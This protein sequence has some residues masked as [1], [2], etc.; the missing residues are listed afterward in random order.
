MG[1]NVID[2][3]RQH[4]L[5][6]QLKKLREERSK[7]STVKRLGSDK[8]T[9]TPMRKLKAKRRRRNKLARISRRKNR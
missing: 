5:F 9:N 3:F 7:R 1:M 4:Y 6:E 2:V 8:A